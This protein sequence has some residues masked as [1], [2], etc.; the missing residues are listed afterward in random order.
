M[1]SAAQ[2]H[3]HLSEAL[4]APEAA[5]STVATVSDWRKAL[6]TIGGAGVTLRELKLSDAA[7]LMALL[8]TEEVT[9]FISPP[10]STLDGFER[11]ILWTQRERSLGRY[12]CFGIVPEN[13]D[14]AVGLIQIRQ[15][16]ATF[17]NAEWGFA[18]GQV[19]W[20]SG[21]FERSARLVLDFAF[22]TLKIH[23]LEA[24]AA[25]Q[26]ARGNGVLRK[27]GATQEGILRRSFLHRGEHLD[28]NLWTLLADDWVSAPDTPPVPVH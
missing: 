13:S 20:G 11:F 23:R 10:P 16:D 8:T 21:L 6:P 7:S 25:V 12:V 15:L 1:D 3:V 4:P 9:R 5:P 17:S 22:D 26:N 2:P 28:Q 27:L 24:R 14:F 19:Y 18:I